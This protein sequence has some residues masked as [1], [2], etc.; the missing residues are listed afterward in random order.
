MSF[1]DHLIAVGL[2]CVVVTVGAIHEQRRP[3][4]GRTPINDTNGRALYEG[5]SRYPA[6]LVA[7]LELTQGSLEDGSTHFHKTLTY[8]PTGGPSVRPVGECP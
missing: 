1:R 6:K 7:Y 5:G 8:E 2:A 4:R 3:R